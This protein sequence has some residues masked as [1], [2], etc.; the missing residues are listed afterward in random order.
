MNSKTKIL[1]LTDTLKL[2]IR[3]EFVQGVNESDE[4]KIYT[5]DELIKKHNVA[6]STIYRIA[7]NEQ[8][9]IQRDQFQ[10]EYTQKLDRDR[11]KNRAKESIKFDDN[12]IS[13]AKA[14]YSTVSYVIQNNNEDLVGGNKGLQPSQ[15]NALANAAFTAQRLAKLALG[16][17]TINIDATV[18]ENTDAFRRAM[19]LL[20]TVEDQRRSQGDGAT[21]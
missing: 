17:A 4:Y 20:D 12:S 3:N 7:R 8:W 6:Q 2:K 10:Q 9:K 16:E 5:L 14:L 1:K 13:L 15:L 19:E 18:N 21:H 11:I